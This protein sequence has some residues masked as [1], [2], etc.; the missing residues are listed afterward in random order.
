MTKKKQST[1]QKIQELQEAIA[2]ADGLA[3]QKSNFLATMSHEIRTP[4]QTI[5]G[6]LELIAAEKPDDKIATM[7]K[8]AQGAASSLLEILDDVLDVAKIDADAMELDVYEVPVRLMVQGIIEALLVKV[9]GVHVTL[10][11]DIGTDVP[12]VVMGDPKRLRQILMNLCSNALKFTH[13][14]H[15]TVR[16]STKVQHINPPRG[17]LGLRFEVIDTGIGMSEEVCN[18]LFTSFTQADNTT[19]RKYGGTGLGLSICKKLV[20]LMDGQIGVISESGKGSTFWFEIPTEEVFTDESRIELPNLEGISVLSV[21]DH[22]QGAKEIQNS[23]ISMGATVEH[24]TS[25]EQAIKLVKQRPFDVAVVDQGLPDGLGLDL[26]R[27]MMTLR[28]YMGM[29]MYTVRDDIGLAHSLQSLGAFYI[30]KPASR[31]GL[32]ETVKSAA[33]QNQGQIEGSAKILI[34]EDTDSVRDILRRQLEH[35]NVDADFVS[36]GNE[37]LEAINSGE[38][39]ILVTDLHMPDVDGYEL[40]KTIRAQEAKIKKDFPIVALSADVQITQ[41]EHYMKHGFDEYLLKPVSL[42][43]LRGLLIR[44][45]L[46]DESMGDAEAAPDDLTP[47][48]DHA[49]DRGCLIKHV[50]AIDDSTVEM[51]NMFIDMTAPLIEK[52]QTAQKD[53]DFKA[54]EELGHSLKGGA[55]SA[56]CIKLGNLADDL[57]ERASAK[58][59]CVRCIKAIIEEFD[60][61]KADIHTLMV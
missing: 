3:Q 45:R 34:A 17:G 33:R 59:G 53:K 56:C 12:F 61:V 8:T 6:I 46:L 13:E 57:Q 55:R 19:S 18:R 52:I 20:E 54:L 39:D 7:I 30:T 14:G 43:Q 15:V 51:M 1:E 50:G 49:I 40:V 31:V 60:R 10:E 35:L 47:T 16:V 9:R 41:R 32:G 38:Y 42:G 21:E 48:S 22:P 29:V 11:D 36:S 26:I 24:C 5:Y 23:L 28:P 37:A 25:C 4:M 44:W 2:Y 58:R 27:E